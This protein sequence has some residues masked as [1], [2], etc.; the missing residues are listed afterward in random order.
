LHWDRRERPNLKVG[1]KVTFRRTFT[2]GDVALF[3]G[4]T[5][6]V[7]P[8]HT[9]AEFVKSTRFGRRS[10]PGLL[11]ASVG[12]HVGGL[13]NVLATDLRFEF[14]APVY[15]GD[16]VTAEVEVAEGDP[17]RNWYRFK[18]RCTN[19][20]GQEVLRGEINGYPGMR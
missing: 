10:V 18:I 1:D 4:A 6:D 5:W 14:L 13:W 20:D 7:N 17:A 9:D 15:V 19:Q 11:T 16:T 8:Y 12:T 3:V 2:E